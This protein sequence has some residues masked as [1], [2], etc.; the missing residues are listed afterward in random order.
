MPSSPT[1]VV[2]RAHA[3]HLLWHRRLAT[4][5]G[6][7]LND[8]SLVWLGASPWRRP[9]RPAACSAISPSAAVLC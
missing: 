8:G 2:A 5:L 7:P 3:T 9:W 1:S 6:S 4:D